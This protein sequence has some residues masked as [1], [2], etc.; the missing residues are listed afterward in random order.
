VVIDSFYGGYAG[1]ID[2][3]EFQ[4]DLN[5]TNNEINLILLELKSGTYDDIKDDLKD[6]IE[7]YLGSEFTCISLDEIFEKNLDYLSSLIFYPL[8]LI[9]IMSFISIISLYN[10]QK[11]GLMEKARD[12]LIMRAIGTKKKSLRR[13]LFLEALFVIIPA[14]ILSLG[15]GMIINSLILLDRTYLPP[16][17]IPF[18]GVGI[19]FAVIIGFNRL[20]LIP[21]MKKINSFTIK[22]FNVY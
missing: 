7:I 5:F 12:F 17:Y 15:L 16:L 21:I 2:I 4:E 10:Y 18:L 13:I 20:S 1:Y 14:L 9:I 6:F 8:I 19:L 11:A 22:D 3:G